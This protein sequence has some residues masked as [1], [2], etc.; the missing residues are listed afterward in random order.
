[1]RVREREWGSGTHQNPKSRD[2]QI[3]MLC[4]YLSDEIR[5]KFGPQAGPKM[6]G[7]FLFLRFICPAILAPEGL[8]IVYDTSKTNPE[9]KLG[10]LLLTKVLQVRKERRN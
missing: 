8:D 6:V 1:M 3:R 5:K 9:G 10:L 2:R 7:A 4:W